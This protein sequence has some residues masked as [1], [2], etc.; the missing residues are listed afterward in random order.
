LNEVYRQEGAGISLCMCFLAHTEIKSSYMFFKLSMYENKTRGSIG[1][2][3][4]IL[5]IC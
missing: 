2:I 3:S 1:M 4:L 5:P